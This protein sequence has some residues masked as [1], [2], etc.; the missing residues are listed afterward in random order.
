M[1][2]TKRIGKNI[3][4]FS[5]A[6]TVLVCGICIES[7]AL[8]K[9]AAGGQAAQEAHTFAARSSINVFSAYDENG[10]LYLGNPSGASDNP[11]V[12][13]D[14]FLMIKNGYALSYNNSKLIPN[15]VSW[16]LED[17]DFGEVKRKNDFRADTLLPAAWYCVKGGSERASG[18]EAAVSDYRF[19][20][21]GFDRG[22]MCPSGDRTKSGELNSETFL[23]TNMIPQAPKNNRHTWRLLEEASQRFA[24]NGFEL[25]IVCGQTGQGGTS[26]KGFFESIPVNESGRSITVPAYTWK[27][28]LVLEKGGNDLLRIDE[29]TLVIAVCMPNSEDCS[30]P[31]HEYAVSVHELERRTGYDFFS[32]LPDNIETVLESRV[33]KHKT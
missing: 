9:N 25:Y 32:A 21:Y 13:A 12:N 23:M 4:P 10:S 20:V 17:S 5:V 22:H 11:A 29:N 8:E 18:Y 2:V 30:L 7:G 15:W 28:V 27:V 1:C 26:Q 3:V 33:Y 31:W 16:H 14:N 19:S 6:L 24:K